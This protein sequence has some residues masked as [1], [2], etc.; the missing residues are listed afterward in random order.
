M[1]FESYCDNHVYFDLS[2]DDWLDSARIYAKNTSLPL[3]YY[4]GGALTA[5]AARDLCFKNKISI[6][7]ETTTNL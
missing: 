6:E 4:G 2:I 3:D 5:V 7:N 1:F